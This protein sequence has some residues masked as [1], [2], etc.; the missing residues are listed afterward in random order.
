M[1]KLNYLLFFILLSVSVFSQNATI[2]GYITDGATNETLI[3]ASVFDSNAKKGAV[4]ND[5]GFFSITLPRGSVAMQFSYIGYSTQSLNF[6]LTKDTVINI[7]LKQH[8]TLSEITVLGTKREIGV[9]GSQMSTIEV[10]VSLIKSVPVL[11][12]ETDVIKVLQLL[13]GI[14]AGTEGSAGFYVR[15]GGPDENLFL[16]DGV[17]IYNVNHAAGFFSAFNADAIKN[18]T[19]Y[20]GGFPARFGGRL[21][22]VVDIRMNDGNNQK[23]KGNVT[24]GLISS[25]INLEGPL[26]S[27]KTTF[28]ISARRTY[29]DILAQP[30]IKMAAKAENTGGG[31]VKAGYYFYDLNAKVSHKFSDKDRLYLSA[32][33]GDDVVYSDFQDSYNV[34]SNTTSESRMQMDW[35]WGNLITALRWNRIINNKLFMNTT[36]TYSRYRFNMLLGNTE[37]VTVKNPASYS[38][39][40]M[41]VGYNSGIEDMGLKVDFDYSPN[42]AN[43][44]KFGANYTNHAFKPGVQVFKSKSQNDTLTQNRDT[45]FGDANIFAH[46]ASLYVED[47]ITLNSFLKLNAGLHYSAFY[48]QNQFYHSLQPRLSV[49]AMLT[50]LLSVKASYASMSQYI[51]LLSNSS[52]S[53]PTDLWVPVTK[54][55]EPMRSHQYSAGVF[56]E[57]GKLFDLSIEGYYKSMNNLIEY[58]DGA[59]FL[60]SS[61]GWEDKVSVG[62]GWAYGVEFLAQ[63]TVG[64]T[65]GWVGYTWSKTERLFDRPGQEINFGRVFPA[66]YDRRHDISLVV[67]HKFS[68]KFDIA[69]TWVYSTGNAGSLAL[70]NYSQPTLP[71]SVDYFNFN[72]SLPHL[73]ARNNYR[74]PSYQRLDLG[75]NFHKQKKYGVRTWSFG[76][77]NAYNQMNPFFI[78]P[79][80]DYGYVYDYGTQSGMPVMTRSLKKITIFPL[81]PSFSYSYKF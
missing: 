15:G 73:S 19:L 55:I 54:R 47:N 24:V 42:T 50:D 45:T 58:K 79:D 52:L 32:Y 65:T 46:E 64:K 22:S 33:M 9:K 37:E 18:V 76:V 27:E 5:Y 66:K 13:P 60:S 63:K 70:Q 10:P 17:P 59:S 51:H 12:G 20:K 74:M 38:F 57:L 1:N 40:K 67:A 36:A 39:E 23:L 69:A 77:Y 31:D 72:R 11:F 30:I 71:E 48:V 81:I 75:A 21:S 29:L 26:F 14:K 6:K 62:R 2:S 28:N 53:L 16:L 61:S 78:Y 35:N 49:R 43:E 68:E 80:Y 4:T 8:T 7:R 3:N 41:S 34:Q 25:K 44:V 56:Y